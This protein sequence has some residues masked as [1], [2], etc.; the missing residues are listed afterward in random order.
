MRTIPAGWRHVKTGKKRATDRFF[1]WSDRW[2]AYDNTGTR[3]LI[4]MP[5]EETNLVIRRIKKK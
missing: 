4:G 1:T 2:K 3:D 5:I